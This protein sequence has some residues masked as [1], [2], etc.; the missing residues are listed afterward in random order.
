MANHMNHSTNWGQEDVGGLCWVSDP[1]Q[2]YLEAEVKAVANGVVTVQTTN[3]SNHA[4]DLQEPLQP[5]SRKKKE[6]PR[7]I[8]QRVPLQSNSGVEN[9]DNLSTLHEAAI[10][11]NIQLRFRMDLMYTNTGPILI[12]MNPFKWLPIYGDDVISRYHGRP[13]GSLPPHC[14]MESEEAFVQL[15]KTRKNQ[16]IVICGESGAGKTETTKLMLYYL[17]I[18]SKRQAEREGKSKPGDKSEPGKLTIAERMVNSN[19]LL[20]AFGN[21]KTLRND[22]SSRFGKFTRYDFAP[23]STV[24]SGGHIENLLLEKV[25]VVEQAPGERNYHIFYQI[26]AAAGQKKLRDGSAG[27]AHLANILGLGTAAACETTSHG[28]TRGCKDVEHLDDVEEYEA[29]IGALDA[30]GVVKNGPEEQR[31]LQVAMA[32]YHCGDVKFV[33]GANDSSTVDAKTQPAMDRVAQLLGLDSAAAQA[34]SDSLLVRVREMRGGETVVSN[35][36]SKQATQLRDAMA[37]AV[38]SMLFDWLVHRANAAFD[39]AQGAE[40]QFIGVLDIFGFEDMT[41]NGFEQVFINTTNEQLQKVFNDIVFKSEEEEYTN[42]QI[43]WDKTVFPDNTPCI[44]LLTK[45]PQGILRLVDAECLRGNAASDGA[46][47]AAKVNKAHGSHPFFEVCGPAS[48]WRRNSGDRTQDEDFLIHHFAGPIC[49]TI[50]NFVEKNRD[51]LFGH[52]H[53]VLSKSSCPIVNDLFPPRD[54]SGAQS[55]KDATVANKYLGQ[56][57]ALVSVLKQSATRFVRCIKTNA[58]K[59]PAKLDKPSVLRQL[60]CSG[61]MAAL[62]VRRAG[63]PTRVTYGD[64]VR[65]FRAFTP[66]GAF[67]LNDN[68]DLTA[69]MMLNAD[70]AKR[71][72]PGQYRLGL[73]KLFLQAEVL[74]ALQS[75]RNA[76]LHPYVRRMQRWWIATQGNIIQRQ[77]KRAAQDFAET[78]SD[79]SIKAVAAIAHVLEAFDD[80]EALRGAA[81]LAATAAGFSLGQENSKGQ[82]SKIV[83]FREAVA[84]AKKVVEEAVAIKEEAYRIRAELLTEIDDAASRCMTLKSQAHELYDPKDSTAL[85]AQALAAEAALSTCRVELAAIASLWDRATQ[86]RERKNSTGSDA[87]LRTRAA[88]PATA[89]DDGLSP[90]QRAA[91]RRARI[92]AALH[93]VRAAEK[94]SL[95]MMEKKHAMDEAR[96]EFQGSLDLASERLGAIQVD[97]FIISGITTVSNAVAAARDAIF[98]AQKALQ[99]VDAE[100]CKAAVAVATR[101]VEDALGVAQHEAAR[102]AALVT[103]DE[104]EKTCTE[105]AYQAVATDIDSAALN[106]ALATADD[107]VATARSACKFP[108]IPA[109]QLATARAVDCVN[110]CGE[111]L[112]QLQLAKRT[113]EKARFN[114]LL[115][116]FQSM[117]EQARPSSKFAGSSKPLFKVKRVSVADENISGVGS[118]STIVNSQFPPTPK[119]PEDV[120]APVAAAPVAAPATPIA[121]PP[122]PEEGGRASS[123]AEWIDEKNLGK[124]AAQI[125]DVAGDLDDLLE[126]EEGDAVDLIRECGMPK[127]A[128]RRFRKALIELG[129][130]VES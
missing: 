36:D 87:V 50:S 55:S 100:P 94:M 6:E 83:A 33:D 124:Y 26:A 63:F 130:K 91:A 115:G 34:L 113:E 65:E 104:S 20:E 67:N 129:A 82:L 77:F 76:L 74:Y 114:K 39:K 42:E 101:A 40:A 112:E 10:L 59:V 51:A 47:L 97:V 52:V 79:A 62:E 31:I 12:A 110:G 85:L 88:A 18:V 89:V 16:A 121:P 127:L 105:I 28:Y 37:K 46:K 126:M 70:V 99:A 80:C 92:D 123:L 116:K 69:K 21:A 90:E 103:L 30:L 71:V 1:A 57:N 111:L 15:A 72:G 11:D 29:M 96:R 118:R 54:D 73:S 61:V 128:A 2:A 108:D 98:A 41:V 4:I 24:I 95:L 122:A 86:K 8:L 125:A 22:N 5:P 56:L 84:R 45:R 68:K 93:L 17:A 60:V 23:D 107:V 27:E 14:F 64:F 25:R 109:L 13:Y 9:M 7:R 48:V 78:Q 117:D 3:G 81:L 106:D 58:E 19:P 119:S 44:E 66:P 49:Y 120:T 35:N 75:I 53:D 38:Y 32:V 43:Q 102:V